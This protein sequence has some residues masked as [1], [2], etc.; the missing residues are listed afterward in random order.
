MGRIQ[1]RRLMW[2]WHEQIAP[3]ECESGT[4]ER[5]ESKYVFHFDFPFDCVRRACAM[6]GRYSADSRNRLAHPQRWKRTVRQDR[7][8]GSC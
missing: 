5:Q 7:P 2:L 1:S 4:H 6:H 8:A 3:A